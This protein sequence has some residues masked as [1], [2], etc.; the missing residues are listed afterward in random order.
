VAQKH[1]KSPMSLTETGAIEKFKCVRYNS[2]HS[3]SI[4]SD[5]PS[6]LNDVQT[7]IEWKEPTKMARKLGGERGFITFQLG[8]ALITRR[9]VGGG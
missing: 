4:Q 3:S 9:G 2:I 8:R 5:G 6:I 1:G 7:L